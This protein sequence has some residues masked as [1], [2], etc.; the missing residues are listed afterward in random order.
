MPDR[1]RIAAFCGRFAV[2]VIL[3][4]GSLPGGQHMQNRYRRLLVVIVLLWATAGVAGRALALTF[5]EFQLPKGSGPIDIT[6]G[7]D[8]AM[9]FTDG[10][11]L[12]VGR[13]TTAGEITEFPMPIPPP[14]GFSGAPF[15]ITAG[16]GRAPR[17]TPPPP[18]ATNSTTTPPPRIP[19]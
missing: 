12:R 17:V 4:A 6:T 8:S 11:G 19:N 2:R 14:G 10:T 15:R 3:R 5:T 13:I 18:R 16:P 9:W 1:P 7:P